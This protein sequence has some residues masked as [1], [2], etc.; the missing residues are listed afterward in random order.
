[1]IVF[2]LTEGRFVH[3][4][5]NTNEGDSPFISWL[6][7]QNLWLAAVPGTDST[8]L[9][10]IEV[11]KSFWR[12]RTGSVPSNDDQIRTIAWLT[13]A[14]E[15]IIDQLT[16]RSGL[17]LKLST[18]NK[19]IFCRIRAP[20]KLLELHASSLNYRL[21][22]KDEI[23]PGSEQF[24]NREIRGV[25]IELEEEKKQYT[26]DEANIILQNL[27]K[28]GKISP[29]DLNVD[30]V[31]EMPTTWTRRVH[32]LE[33]IADNVPTYN[34]YVTYLPFRIEKRLRYLYQTYPSIRGKTLF[35]S[36]DRIY[37]TKSIIDKYFD[38]NVL[39][40]SARNHQLPVIT[41]IM[42]L[43][44][45]NRGELI[46]IDKL[47][48]RWISFWRVNSFEV[49]SPSV[50]HLGYEE[51]ESVPMYLH[52]F[53]QPLRDIRDYFGEK[54]SLYFA[55]FGY[56]LYFLSIPA[57]LGVIMVSFAFLLRFT[58]YVLSTF[59]H[60]YDVVTGDNHSVSRLCG[61]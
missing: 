55:W 42:A 18:N 47:K 45:S 2:P 35:R 27:Y 57:I 3:Y 59:T 9:Q 58:M 38:C 39:A 7:I 25:P 29:N 48:K 15:A 17:Q 44:D 54:I 40:D 43:H 52:P 56:Y 4:K 14:R 49:G 36:K 51:D 6:D 50:T 22:I 28:A 32:A 26:K 10:S 23:D 1:M 5:A 46:T 33:R 34:K 60:V 61:Y 11:L 13:I 37:L 24:W 8:K 19:H 30:E 41:S 31:N 16:S 12:K 53:S 20:V 21:Q